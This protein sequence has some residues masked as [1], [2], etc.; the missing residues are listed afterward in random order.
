MDGIW[1]DSIGYI[2]LLINLYSMSVKGEY[3][4][5]LLSAIANCI[6]IG[7]GFLIASTP[8][9]VGCIIAVG[10]HLY[11]LHQLKTTVRYD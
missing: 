10:L 3:H 11:R 6:Y 2:A 4:L 9:I 7:Y 5:R 8:I 1:I